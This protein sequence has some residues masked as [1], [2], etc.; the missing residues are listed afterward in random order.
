LLKRQSEY[1]SSHNNDTT[2]STAVGGRGGGGSSAGNVVLMD[3]NTERQVCSAVLRLLHDNS[4]DVQAIAVKTLG[5]LLTTVHAEQ[6]AE[7]AD[8][9]VTRVLDISRTEL[10]DVFTIGLRTLV[11]TI[12]APIGNTT[13]S[14]RLVRPLLEG[15]RTNSMGVLDA[16]KQDIILSSLDVL[17][18][19][20][21]R[22]GASSVNLT[23]QHEP[24]LQMCLQQLQRTDA[25]ATVPG[26]GSANGNASSTSNALLIRKR[27]GNTLGCL[28]VVL[29]DTLLQR[30]VDSILQLIEQCTSGPSNT[31]ST[32]ATTDIRALIR[33]MCTIAGAVGQR[34][35]QA[36]LDR[37]LPIL[38]RFT[39][40]KEAITRDDDDDD[41]DEDGGVGDDVTMS[42]AFVTSG[43]S[44]EAAVQLAN[45]LRESCFVGF[46]SF[47]LRCPHEIEAHLPNIIRAAL[48]FMA[49]DPNY[50]YGPDDDDNDDG[51]PAGDNDDED[52]YGAEDD[53][54]FENG[55]DEFDDEDDDDD[56]ESW[57]VRRSA[58]RVLL[59]IVEA[60]KHDP[61]M[62]LWKT[63]WHVR[64]HKQSTVAAALVSRFKEREENCRVAVIECFSRLLDV[65]I[66]CN[67]NGTLQLS[68]ISSYSDDDNMKVDEDAATTNLTIN[69]HDDYSSKVVKACEKI[70]DIKKGSE[71]SKSSVLSLLAKLSQTPGGICGQEQI[72]SV[73]KHIKVFLSSAS[74]NT[75]S[76][77]TTAAIG[78]TKALRL[79]ALQLAHAMLLSSSGDPSYA[80]PE[81]IRQSLRST[82]LPELCFA[83][84][85]QWY[86]VIAE[87]LRTIAE[88]PRFFT[89]VGYKNDE[90]T[91]TRQQ[92]VPRLQRNCLQQLSH[93]L[94]S[95]M[96]TKR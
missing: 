41:E 85:E 57:K 86:K 26:V 22:F 6:V 9:L 28:S 38:L 8:S 70:L 58:I 2:T 49:Y 72:A 88:V 35:G 90:D 67:K 44:E 87:A 71:R 93:F 56:D 18:D 3:T 95:T 37:I 4:N 40:P 54:E 19:L 46:E 60:K 36:Q 13:V 64:K 62:T 33:T 34:L 55:D 68:S 47:L 73:F 17:T 92:N 15:I 27:A 81:K 23:R 24:I 1:I 31:G 76:T 91:S 50:S 12:P 52:A 61:I 65:T 69:F 48:A 89:N 7:I 94:Q 42:N 53:E 83:V 10:R 43:M 84:Q 32:N 16:N 78:T 66:Q 82:L 63:K 45:E 21:G 51:N 74:D 25:T 11:K 30:M 79:D 20:I 96:L 75:T 59:G 39:N 5:V 80:N 77:A 14:D 29:S